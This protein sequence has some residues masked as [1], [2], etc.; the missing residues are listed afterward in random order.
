MRI[1]P[2][3][4]SS[5][6]LTNTRSNRSISRVWGLV[7]FAFIILYFFLTHHRERLARYQRTYPNSYTGSTILPRR[8]T[9]TGS[10]IPLSSSHYSLVSSASE[11]DSG[12][13]ILP[14]SPVESSA[15]SSTLLRTSSTSSSV[16]TDQSFASPSSSWW[17]SIGSSFASLFSSSSSS[18]V[19][20][21]LHPPPVPPMETIHI[22]Y[23]AC[24]IP[25]DIEEDMFGLLSLKSVLLARANSFALSRYRYMF[26]IISSYS[27]GDL[28]NTTIINYD[29]RKAIENDP[30]VDMRI[31]SL[32]ELDNA[33]RKLGDNPD[34]IP[35]TIFKP[36]AASRLKLP[37]ILYY[38]HQLYQ[39]N[40]YVSLSKYYEG[41]LGKFY[42][43]PSSIIYLDW[44]T[45]VTC[46][47]VRLYE[48]FQ[49]FN[50]SQYIGF[51]L[52]DPTG[53]SEKDIYKEWNLPRPVQGAIS[54]G[55]MMLDLDKMF[56]NN[57]QL[58]HQYW[59]SLYQV[60]EEK[61]P[62]VTKADFWTL[63]NAFPLGDQDVLNVYL[64]KYNDKLYIIPPEYNWCLADLVPFRTYKEKYSV[65]RPIPC[66]YHVCG[67]RLFSDMMKQNDSP[68]DKYLKHLFNYVKYAHI[69]IPETPPGVYVPPDPNI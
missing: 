49:Y 4:S 56:R 65:H 5:S 45:L 10:S 48:Q 33:V 36:C 61:V 18:S 30:N 59:L 39:Q 16:S 2:K 66:I 32:D 47:L 13:R 51:A 54:S 26:H 43:L 19:P 11:Q 35:H 8:S 42:D 3:L 29:V 40:D 28:L 25:N 17:S 34:L 64:H 1:L 46:D 57:Q 24:G 55:V 12:N 7:L 6:L 21:S 23:T 20:A 27:M 53:Q 31:Y 50:S 58:L 44:D 37:Y 9:G 63:T 67:Q 41:K 22:A 38:Q 62:N 60:L 69:G 14:L 15:S 52:N 68:D